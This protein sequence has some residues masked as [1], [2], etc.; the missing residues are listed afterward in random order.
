VPVDDLAA[1]PRVRRLSAILTTDLRAA[2]K[3]S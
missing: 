1:D 2:E 3:N